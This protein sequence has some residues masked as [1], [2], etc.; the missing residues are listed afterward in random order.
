MFGNVWANS[1]NNRVN[2]INDSRL[3]RQFMFNVKRSLKNLFPDY[4]ELE[5]ICGAGEVVSYVVYNK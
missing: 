4:F 3:L 1:F 5:P 2:G